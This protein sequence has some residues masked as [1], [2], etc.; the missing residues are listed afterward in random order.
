MEFFDILILEKEEGRLN[1]R[2]NSYVREKHW[3]V[4][5]CMGPAGIKPIT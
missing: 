2:E 1:E 3:L 5:S 4:A